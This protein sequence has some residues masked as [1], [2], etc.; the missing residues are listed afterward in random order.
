MSN[1]ELVNII[2]KYITPDLFGELT[3][4]QTKQL[5]KI[6]SCIAE[7]NQANS[8]RLLQEYHDWLQEK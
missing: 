8:L 7:I 3:A 4:K 6:I 5:I 2:R 1:E